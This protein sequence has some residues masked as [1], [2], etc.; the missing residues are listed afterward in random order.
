MSD[1][2]TVRGN[3]A[4]PKIAEI[5]ALAGTSPATVSKVIN[6]YGSVSDATRKRIE[7][8]LTSVHYSKKPVTHVRSRNIALLIDQLTQTWVTEMLSG[9]LRYANRNGLNLVVVARRDEQGGLQP[10]YMQVLR[11]AKPLAVVSNSADLTDQ[12]RGLFASIHT[13]YA[14]VDYRGN[15]AADGVEVRL[16]NW[17]GGVAVGQY[18]IGLGHRR[19]AIM[20]GPRDMTCF[21]ARFDG[22]K[23]ALN[24]A[25]IDLD[26]D[27][28]CRADQWSELARLE[29]LR[30]FSMPTP[31][32]AIFATCDTQVV[33]IFDAAHQMGVAIPGDVSVVG[34][35][36]NEYMW[37]V[38]TPLTT[39]RGPYSDMADRA[40]QLLLDKDGPEAIAASGRRVLVPPEL[41]VRDSAGPVRR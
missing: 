22:F 27:L 24:E 5:A 17:S 34:F 11:R 32:T 12:E 26:P 8:V 31:P 36:D 16:D 21:Q 14:I 18:L 3:T 13:Q 37:H 28:M 2:S 38:S 1:H 10:D 7:Q 35:D 15:V 40:F 19:I 41:I 20:A 33:G 23:A 29:A 4:R 6:G 39:M 30:L 9:S 25:S